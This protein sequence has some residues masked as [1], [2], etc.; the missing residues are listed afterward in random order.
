[1]VLDYKF[2]III[3]NTHFTVI[4]KNILVYKYLFSIKDL[5]NK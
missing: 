3:K 2:I 5:R 1:M 4:V